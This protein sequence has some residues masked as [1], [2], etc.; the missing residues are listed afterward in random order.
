MTIASLDK[1][2][3]RF[4]LSPFRILI[5]T[6]VFLYILVR[7]HREYHDKHDHCGIK[8]FVPAKDFELSKRFYAD[9]GFEL[10]WSSGD[11]AYF[12]GGGTSFCFNASM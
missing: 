5:L 1:T 2:R 7:C 12:H 9:L 10:A 4:C 11:L 3:S 6:K 8:A